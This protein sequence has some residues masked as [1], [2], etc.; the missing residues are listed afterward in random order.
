MEKTKNSQIFGYVGAGL[1]LLTLLFPFLK[2]SV[3]FFS[4]GFGL[5]FDMGKLGEINGLMYLISILGLGVLGYCA[6]I[7][8]KLKGDYMN[9]S[10]AALAYFV[11]LFIMYFI[12]K[13]DATGQ[14]GEFGRMASDLIKIGMGIFMPLLAGGAYYLAEK[15][16][17]KEKAQA[18]E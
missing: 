13:G 6:Y 16:A 7:T 18:Q 1:M 3:A 2:V 15:A 5:L 9:A 10:Y 14:A 17:I 4:Q 12:V 11:I 8:F